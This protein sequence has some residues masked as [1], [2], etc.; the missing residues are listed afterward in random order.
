MTG[1]YNQ[2]WLT[3]YNMEYITQIEIDRSM[4]VHDKA[5]VKGMISETSLLAYQNIM[6]GKTVI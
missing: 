5:Y 4:N 1:V 3:P 2:A 6:D